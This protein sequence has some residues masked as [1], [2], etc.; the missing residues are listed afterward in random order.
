MR[1]PKGVTQG[2]FR[3]KRAGLCQDVWIRV[4]VSEVRLRG[5]FKTVC[6][7]PADLR[8]SLCP[9][10]G[11]AG[12]SRVL[13]KV[14]AGETSALESHFCNACEHRY[15]GRG[16]TAEWFQKYYANEWDTGAADSPA[17][18]SSLRKAAKRI[19]LAAATRRF[20]K[21]RL[22]GTMDYRVMQLLPML[23]GVIG[24]DG[25]HYINQPGMKRVLEV[26]CGAGAVLHEMGRMGLE[27]VGTEASPAR[28][29]RCRNQGLDVYECPVDSMRPVESKGPFDLVYSIHV[30]EHI[31]DAMAHFKAIS[32]VLRDGGYV[33][34]QVP[35][36]SFGEV[37]VL[38]AHYPG[39]CH[40]F[41]ARS[42]SLLLENC[43]FSVVRWQVDD[44]V[45][46]LARKTG[47]PPI[48]Q[49]PKNTACLER[50]IEPLARAV[51]DGREVSYLWHRCHARVE[52]NPGEPPLY[53]DPENLNRGSTTNPSSV[54]IS[55]SSPDGD[56]NFPVV[57]VHKGPGAPMWLKVN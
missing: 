6:L 21:R 31:S 10:C 2:V 39:H 46:I 42:L 8:S 47:A 28:V 9:I 33:Y 23:F 1:T 41:S 36:V 26:G 35:H 27:A 15:F 17:S 38:Q 37:L 20:I 45:Q 29:E 34:V 13:T 40:G 22:L 54:R 56:L 16:P 18:G 43:G 12:N 53:L 55:C 32:T 11:S 25:A 7:E 3:G 14:Q 48:S 19:P 52:H 4:D 24:G 57:F 44:N 5:T 50:L 30:L 51:R 49:A